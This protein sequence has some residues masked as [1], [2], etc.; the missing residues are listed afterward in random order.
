[1]P[2][3]PTPTPTPIPSTPTPTPSPVPST[4]T[5]TPVVSYDFPISTGY[6]DSTGA[7]ADSS[8]SRSIYGSSPLFLSN[9]V[10]YDD[11]N[12]TVIYVGSGFYYQNTA[13]G[14]Y[15]QID[16]SGNQTAGGTC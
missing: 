4:P 14:Q 10:F 15:V 12:L 6:G 11:S 3:T 2:S 16:N 7:C 1:M 9:S 8:T 5:P 13:N